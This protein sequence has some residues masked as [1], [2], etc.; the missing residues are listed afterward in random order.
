MS[1]GRSTDIPG[2]L[3]ALRD[4][5][6]SEHQYDPP[7]AAF[8]QVGIDP[9][10]HCLRKR[11]VLYSALGGCLECLVTEVKEQQVAKNLQVTEPGPELLSSALVALC[12][13][14]A[15][16][17]N[18]RAVWSGLSLVKQLATVVS[19]G[20]GLGVQ[21]S[22]TRLRSQAPAREE[23]PEELPR[24]DSPEPAQPQ[25]PHPHHHS[26]PPHHPQ[27]HQQQPPQ[28]EEV[29][30][31]M[32]QMQQ[33]SSRDFMLQLQQQQLAFQ[34]EQLL[35]SRGGPGT[36]QEDDTPMEEPRRLTAES[37]ARSP[38]QWGAFCDQ[39]AHHT[40]ALLGVLKERTAT[41]QANTDAADAAAHCHAAIACA[42]RGGSLDE[43]LGVLGDALA[44]WE[45]RATSGRAGALAFKSKVWAQ[46]VVPADRRAAYAAGMAAGK[47]ATKASGG[48][49]GWSRGPAQDS[50]NGGGGGKQ[51]GRGR[52]GSGFGPGQ[53]FRPRKE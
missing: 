41:L 1:A 10:L 24:Q 19:F 27:H 16:D 7:V 35:L 32:Q 13:F 20:D 29:L 50:G 14:D 3:E 51:G 47:A 18:R 53:N 26:Q 36:H 9:S 15:A 43:M 22:I 49:G 12:G 44:F 40:D 38:A 23:V 2:L 37:V 28:M 25:Q 21:E 33:E 31:R 39:Q 34:R 48:G 52:G 6:A 17:E 8:Q 11:K 46:Q 42:L 4:S 5:P 45:L 30:L